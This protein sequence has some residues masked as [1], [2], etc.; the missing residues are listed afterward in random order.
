MWEGS[1]KI[2]QLYDKPIKKLIFNPHKP[3][4]ILANQDT[5]SSFDL[6]DPEKELQLIKK[7][8]FLNDHYNLYS[9][10]NTLENKARDEYECGIFDFRNGKNNDNIICK[11]MPVKMELFGRSL[12]VATS[13]YF[14]VYDTRKLFKPVEHE[15]VKGLR[16]FLYEPN[17]NKL[18]VGC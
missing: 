8:Y 6:N 4:I 17:I 3:Q 13:N 15:P 12:L 7:P 11:D 2:L 5:I 10:S 18:F 14:E 16:D 1:K 9:I